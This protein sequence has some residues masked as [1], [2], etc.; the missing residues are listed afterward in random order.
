MIRRSRQATRGAAWGCSVEVGQLI[1]VPVS[2]GAL[3][4]STTVVRSINERMLLDHLRSTGPQSRADLARTTTLSKPTVSLALANL[5][6][7]GLVRPIGLVA[8][9]PG[10]AALLYEA[11]PTAGYVA[12]VDIGRDWVRVAVA[13]LA[14]RVLGRRNGV[15]RARTGPALVAEV[16]RLAHEA[17]SDAGLQ[18]TDIV[19]T[20]LASPGVLDARAGRLDLASNLPGWGRAGLLSELHEA[21]GDDLVVENDINLAAIGERTFGK[22]QDIASFVLLS[23][24]T[25][26]GLGI[27]ID[28]E[29]YRGAHGRAGEVAFLPIPDESTGGAELR[30]R[31]RG[32][33]E[34]LAAAE[35]VVRSAQRLGMTGVTTAR[36]VFEA[37]ETGDA[38]ALAAVDLEG[39]R[40]GIAITAITAIADPEVVVLAG[41]VGHNLD[42][43]RA[44]IER[45][46]SALSPLAPRVERSELGEDAA[47][48]G[49]LATALDHAR[50]SVFDARSG[51]A[52]RGLA[53][54]D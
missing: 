49:A 52:T 54:A 53:A 2:P 19:H 42:L 35:G 9:R 20:V 3:L 43:L 48:L 10:R 29:L 17:A 16:R 14:G 1:A 28:G 4:G 21:L 46:L 15:N 26:T 24:G 41:G 8:G 30:V 33:F 6:A 47:L 34:E 45:Q 44:S 51:A 23:V 22:G 25:G 18:W 38:L 40:I 31:T 13:D 5:E 50:S 27:V 12:G 32:M 7:A 36:Q 37:A 39:S 11:D